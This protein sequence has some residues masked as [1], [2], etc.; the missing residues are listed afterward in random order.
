MTNEHEHPADA[1]EQEI[2]SQSPEFDAAMAER[3]IEPGDRR[4]TT[5]PDPET[6]DGAVI[7][8]SQAC[9]HHLCLTLVADFLQ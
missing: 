6:N 2:T 4:K 5:L 8:I 9:E 7:R 3:T 1:P